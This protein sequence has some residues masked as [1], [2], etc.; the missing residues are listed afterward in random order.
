MPE[1]YEFKDEYEPF[2]SAVKTL[3]ESQFILKWI[4]YYHDEKKDDADIHPFFIF[5]NRK[6]AKYLLE[7]QYELINFG[8]W[9]SFKKQLMKKDKHVLKLGNIEIISNI[10]LDNIRIG[11]LDFVVCL[12]HILHPIY[13][14]KLMESKEF[15]SKALKLTINCI[16][17]RRIHPIT[18][19]ECQTTKKEIFD[20]FHFP[21]NIPYSE[22][23]TIDL[24]KYLK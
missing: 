15:L 4:G 12:I 7:E 8:D 5:Q 3:I 18:G 1:I 9:I 24:C 6:N 16:P 13:V 14:E 22:N 17:K 21:N 19:K 20:L 2:Y 11:F 23:H 10:I